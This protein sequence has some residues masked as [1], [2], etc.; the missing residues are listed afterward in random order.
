MCLITNNPIFQQIDSDLIVYKVCLLESDDSG[1]PQYKFIANNK[2]IEFDVLYTNKDSLVYL[3][4]AMGSVTI[5]SGL[6]HFFRYESDAE[7]VSKELSKSSDKQ[8][9]V[10]KGIIPAHSDFIAGLTYWGSMSV[11]NSI[12]SKQVT[13]NK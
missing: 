9:T 10:I 2:P 8:Y 5:F 1:V 6:F 7:F 4:N 13:F 12:V 3:Q 11:R